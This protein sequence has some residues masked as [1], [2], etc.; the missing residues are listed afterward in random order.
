MNR[1]QLVD[2]IT[3]QT[4]LIA[5]E[6]IAACQKFVS[7]RYELI[8]NSFLW[9]DTLGGVNINID[10]AD[11]NN[12]EGIVLLPEVIDHV[13][14]IRQPSNSLRVYGMDD[15][16]RI[17]YDQF[18]QQG[19]AWKFALLSP[20]WFIWRG[21][22]GLTLNAAQDSVIPFKI[23]WRDETG[24]QFVNTYTN[25]ADF[26]STNL[27]PNLIPVTAVY[28]GSGN[29]S[30][31]VTAGA[32]YSF[33]GDAFRN[34]GGTP[35]SSPAALQDNSNLYIGNPGDPVNATLQ[36]W[37]SAKI[38]IESVFK[39]ATIGTVSL[40][41]QSINGYTQPAGGTLQPTDT[42]SP[43][44]QR[45]RLFPIP[46]VKV[47]LSVLG[48]RKFVPL[49]YDQEVP[50]IRNLD[51]CLIAFSCADMLTVARRFAQAQ[52]KM[53]EGE[54]LLKELAKLYAIQEANFQRF[55][56]DSTGL[57]DPWTGPN[58]SMYWGLGGWSG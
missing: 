16:Y 3:T 4:G 52:Q 12:K 57:S 54:I 5:P 55:I 32:V 2:Y 8:Y 45:I 24:A 35:S 34:G 37:S 51:N 23:T 10:P 17:D 39:P 13:V 27:G 50:L 25:M 58:Q 9:K 40:D 7:K 21:V 47:V 31:T 14:A 20:L 43:S 19:S 6:D 15:F 42:V 44:Y 49:D 26:N 11:A 30:I 56:P 1:A 48:K 18:T 29:Y 53:Q 46:F 36:L 22:E 28:D 33:T 41:G 38:E